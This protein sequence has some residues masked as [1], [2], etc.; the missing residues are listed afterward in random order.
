M[1]LSTYLVKSVKL[2]NYQYSVF[3][4]FLKA[5]KRP[6]RDE[7]IIKETVTRVMGFADRLALP[8]R[9]LDFCGSLPIYNVQEVDARKESVHNMQGI[10]K[11]K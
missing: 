7:K 10:G 9:I 1:R 8:Q 5:T 4:N 2:I 11:T 6:M 3:S